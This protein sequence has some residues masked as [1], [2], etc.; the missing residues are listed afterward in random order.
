MSKLYCTL[1]P[2]TMLR[3]QASRLRAQRGV[4]LLI[5]LMALVMMSLAAVGLIRMVDTGTLV[6]GNLSFKQGATSAADGGAEAGINWLLQ[7][8]GGS[9]LIDDMPDAGYYATSLEELDVIGRSN[10]VTR[11]LVDWNDDDCAYAAENSYGRCIKPTSKNSSYGYTTSYIITRMCKTVGDPNATGNGCAKPMVTANNRTTSRDG[12]DYRNQALPP[13]ASGPY[14]RI[15]VR[16]EGP[17][18]TLSYTET[19]VYF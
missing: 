4:S 1:S 16:S 19:Y 14:F 5:V 6:V 10:L 2:A 11:V 17:R 7:N 3:Y 8:G 18:N 13:T 15:V 12:N 9:M